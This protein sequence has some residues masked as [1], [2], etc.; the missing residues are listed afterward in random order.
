MDST[1]GNDPNQGLKRQ[2]MLYKLYI[3]AAVSV[4]IAVIASVYFTISSLPY[5]HNH[6]DLRVECSQFLLSKISA[7]VQKKGCACPE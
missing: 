6:P 5:N 2:N 3:P 7:R 1:Q 4:L